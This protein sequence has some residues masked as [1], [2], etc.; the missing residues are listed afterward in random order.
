MSEKKRVV[1]TGMGVM[2]PIGDNLE[3]YYNNLIAGKSAIT[4]WRSLDTS[5]IRCKWG[6]TII[7]SI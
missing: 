3:D 5:K 6:T 4:N 1:V 2:T 7:K